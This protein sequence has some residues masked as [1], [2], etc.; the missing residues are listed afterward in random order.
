M[1]DPVHVVFSLLYL[2]LYLSYYFWGVLNSLRDHQQSA[3]EKLYIGIF[4]IFT[5]YKMHE[6]FADAG[7]FFLHADPEVLNYS[8]SFGQPVPVQ[9]YKQQCCIESLLILQQVYFFL[10][11]D[12]AL[13]KVIAKIRYRL[14]S[15]HSL[16][17]S[18]YKFRVCRLSFI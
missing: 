16:K 12:H 14:V 15:I 2:P 18:P 11:V 1:L 17:C 5:E 8:Y 7:W 9:L 6:C 13:H 4:T 10:G 3:N